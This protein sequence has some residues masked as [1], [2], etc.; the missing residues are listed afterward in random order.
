MRFYIGDYLSDTPHLTLEQHGAY[1]L[2]LMAMWRAGGSLPNDDKKLARIVGLTVGKWKRVASEVMP[3]FTVNDAKITQKRLQKEYEK[4]LEFSAKQSANASSKSLKNKEADG[5][6]AK[7]NPSLKPARARVPLS[8]SLL[9]ENKESA[10]REEFEATFWP[11]YPRKV[12]RAP[13]LVSFLKVR[14]AGTSLEDLISG[15]ARIDTERPEY[16]P[17]AAT[18]LNQERW[19][20]EAINKANSLVRRNGAGFY[21]KAGSPEFTAHMRDAERFK[22]N[23]KFWGM[24]AAERKGEEYHVAERFPR[25]R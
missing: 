10:F 6:T 4:A 17:H 15:I 16:I 13:A 12:A 2:L 14:K 5:A 9:K 23:D 3:F 24:K 21:I 19:Q 1:L 8:L 11:A 25:Q 18:W 22:D 20:D 7:P